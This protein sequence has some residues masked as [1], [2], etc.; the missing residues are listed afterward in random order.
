LLK[1]ERRETVKILRREFVF[2]IVFAILVATICYPVNAASASPQPGIKNIAVTRL[3]DE[4]TTKK[5]LFVIT[6]EEDTYHIIVDANITTVGN[7]ALIDL[8]ATLYN[9]LNESVT[10]S[11]RIPDTLTDAPYY[12]GPVEAFD[13]YL[14]K[15]VVDQ[16]KFWLPIVIVVAFIW[17]IVDIIE[18][19][20][21]HPLLETLKT[22]FFGG[23][24][25]WASLPWVLLTILQDT[26][27]D[28]S[29]DM[30]FPYLPL[31]THINLILNKNY[32]I[33]TKLSWWRISEH[34]AYTDVPIPWWLGGGVWHIVWYTYCVA[35]WWTTRIHTPVKI[36]PTA[37]FMWRPNEPV[38]DEN[39]TFDGSP[40]YAPSGY[41]TT[42]QWSF[43]DSS[44][45]GTGISLTHSYV[46]PGNYD[47]TLT[48]TDNNSLTN[49]T[50]HSISVQ[51]QPPP[52]VPRLGIV[53]DYLKVDVVVGQSATA[54]FYIGET[55]N[56]TDLLGVNFAALDFSKT[57]D[58]QTIDSG[59]VTFDKNGIT[60]PKGTWT[61]V[62][63][64]FHAPPDSPTGWYS[65][66]I[67]V[68]S[69]KDGDSTIFVDLVVYGPPIA[70]FTWSPLIPKVG[71]LA[72]FDASLSTS[73]AGPIMEYEWDFG[74]GQT[75]SAP[76]ANHIYT[77]AAIYMVTLNVTDSKGLWNIAQK[78]VQV[79]PLAA[80]IA[81][82]HDV[83][84][85]KSKGNWITAYIELPDGYNVSDI[86][87]SRIRLNGTISAELE[88]IAIGD[89]DNDAVPDM[90]VKF[91]RTDVI[92]YV[93]S[94]GVEYGN[95]TL[96]ITGQVVSTGKPART[97]AF[98]G[99]SDIKVSSLIGDVNCDG[100]VNIFDATLALQC[101]GSKE[102]SPN[103]NPNANFAEEW[104]RINL[105]DVITL[106]YHYG[107][108]SP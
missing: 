49:A 78:Q 101:Y 43:G 85:L 42:Y 60:V 89:Y 5:T 3:I 27:P 69:A 98:E 59:N 52:E 6:T 80:R 56:Q 46:N 58:S 96:T 83:L 25:I 19:F 28:G 77:N 50:T 82:D 48:V 26:N 84:N 17:Q 39:V 30:Y 76:T 74:D 32:Y 8:I 47:V 7:E 12:N 14:T 37:E 2:C 90:M 36:S 65:G 18:D 4:P 79:I 103:W 104:D 106:I 73:T 88:P 97:I 10:A 22:L 21:E 40:S 54:E 71:E 55:L 57:L 35:Q 16:L 107:Q 87:V 70:D 100:I 34:E 75:A 68:T 31:N 33:A 81:F 41:I 38:V 53:P 86:D 13:L 9:P 99:S 23:P 20:I 91:N 44:P 64:T 93:L 108:T 67:T 11:A 45:L 62:T 61:N 102:G 92:D 15:W 72:T 66:N 95:V 24:F 29:I 105:Y 63:V 1:G 94:K 51:I